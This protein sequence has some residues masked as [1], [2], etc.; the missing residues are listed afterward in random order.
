MPNGA[1]AFTGS[2]SVV[3]FPMFAR[4]ASISILTLASLCATAQGA[5]AAA[6]KMIAADL[7]GAPNA[8]A[9]IVKSV[10]FSDK[11]SIPV[12]YTS[13]GNNISFP[14]SWS[15]GPATTKTYA[16]IVDDPD[17]KPNLVNHWSLFNLPA[18][19]RQLPEGLS[20]DATLPDLGNAS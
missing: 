19:I 6:T 13:Y 4:I 3:R 18:N 14:L 15:P 2:L 11:A 10:A 17:A 16:V 20:K 12:R 8:A 1:M 7:I 9:L 5:G